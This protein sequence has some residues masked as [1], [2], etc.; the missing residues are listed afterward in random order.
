MSHTSHGLQAVLWDMDGTLVD[1]EPYWMEAEYALVA[2]HGGRWSEEHAHAVVG[3]P[4]LV[5]AE[6]MRRHAGLDLPP[7]QIVHRLQDHVI[8]QVTRVAHWRP[9]ARELLAEL[10]SA[11]VPCA[12]VTMSWEPL[13]QAVVQQ[14]PPG[15]FAAVVTGDQVTEG[16]PHPEPYTTAMRLLDVQPH[17]S[18]AIEDSLT[19]LRSA[20]AA[21]AVAVGVPHLV[22]IPPA[23]GRILLNGLA[24]VRAA[25]LARLVT[26]ARVGVDVSEP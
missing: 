12:L 7:L 18:V 16:K 2:E 5:T 15:S 8:E 1:T 10:V 3:N 17:R 22:P 9:G 23:P 25:D 19:G 11:G 21:G 20:E 14:L 13:A 6:Y 4:L 24:G 26:E